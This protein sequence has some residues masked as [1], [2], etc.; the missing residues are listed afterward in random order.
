MIIA[1]LD[2]AGNLLRDDA[3]KAIFPW[4]SFT[5][6]VIAALVLRAAE[7]GLL[8]LDARLPDWPFTT[9]Q[10]LQHRAGL[11]DYGPLPAYKTA[12]AQGIPPWPPSRMLAEAK[13]KELAYPP[14]QG[15]LYSNI[16]F[17]LLRLELEK[18]HG[19]GLG[20]ILRRDILQPLG[21]SARLAE[22]PED[23]DALHWDAKGYHPGWVYHGCLMG[24]AAD[25][26]RL[27]HGLLTGSI[28]THAARSSML[29]Q[30]MQAGPI[31]GRVWKE[32]GYGLGIMN[33]TAEGAGRLIGHTGCGPFC[34]NLVARF[35]DLPGQPIAAAFVHGGNET[36]AEFAAVRAALE[37]AGSS[38]ENTG[39][40]GSEI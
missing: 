7:K 34:A 26:A 5:K 2:H 22:T 30:Q 8:D 29:S 12:V 15:W 18:L 20:Q 36:P 25:A 4:W 21:L 27:L 24:T 3:S 10:L 17:L 28:L 31:P 35:P 23:F 1:V 33:G 38:S 32:T 16:G 37:A 13:A 39:Y 14:G 40:P 11:R 6:P 19:C 9:R